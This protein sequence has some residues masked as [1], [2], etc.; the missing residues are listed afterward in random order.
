MPAGRVAPEQGSLRTAQDLHCVEVERRESLEDRIFEDH[1]VIDQADRLRCVEVEV[2]I[3]EAANVEAREG[4]PE[5]AFDV[6]ARHPSGEA[7]DVGAACVDRGQLLRI[8][9]ADGHREFWRFSERRSA[10]T[11]ISPRPAGWSAAAGWGEAVDCA[12]AGVAK[13]HALASA[14]TEI[15]DEKSRM[16]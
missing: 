16:I 12:T 9:G 5:R 14:M 10:V 7:T 6:E 13:A 11:M 4:A 3:A 8:D 2:G 1:V 15:D